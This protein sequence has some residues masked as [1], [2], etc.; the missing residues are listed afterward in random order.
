[1]KKP[2][3]LLLAVFMLFTLTAC[4]GSGDNGKDD[5]NGSE[6]IVV[7]DNE[8]CY[9]AI[10]GIN[11][12]DESEYVLNTRIENKTDDTDYVFGILSASVNGVYCIPGFEA[13]AAAGK[14]AEENVTIYADDF[15][16][17]DIGEYTDIEL[18]FAMYESEF[19]YEDPIAV[20]TVHVYPAGEENA[21]LFVR[22]A[23]DS[24]IVLVDNEYITLIATGFGSDEFWAYKVD[25]YL[26]NKTD[27]SAMFVAE[28]TTVNGIEID[29][30]FA[31]D[32]APGKCRFC[33]MA[34]SEADFE[35]AEI[36]NVESVEFFF[37]SYDEYIWDTVFAE[38][39][40]SIV[41]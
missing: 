4:G 22:E 18:T 19:W 26:V 24:D 32:V 39:Q 13:E 15:C 11:A 21:R 33:T 6:D 17:V 7:I 30:Y 28:N 12:D 37:S 34:F 10:T 14:S 40:I 36:E 25:L 2:I 35:F 8:F 31:Y 5:D 27:A 38:E 23:Q 3:S 29:P 41:P 9:L 1:M 16:G 20:E